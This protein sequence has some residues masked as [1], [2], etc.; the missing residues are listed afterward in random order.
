M[1]RISSILLSSALFPNYTFLAVGVV[2]HQAFDLGVHQLAELDLLSNVLCGLYL[3]EL[4]Q[5][6]HVGNRYS[7]G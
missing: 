7:L 5:C 3:L 1:G 2:E 4:F 6:L